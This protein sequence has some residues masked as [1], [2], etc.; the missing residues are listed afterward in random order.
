[1]AE[2]TGLVLK[3]RRRVWFSGRTIASQ[4]INAS[5]ILATRTI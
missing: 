3:N 5:P 2:N 1:V 4:A